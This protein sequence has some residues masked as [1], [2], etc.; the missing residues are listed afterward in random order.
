MSKK[1]GKDKRMEGMREGKERKLSEEERTKK[2][3][4]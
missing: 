1:K 2:M 4:E 3:G